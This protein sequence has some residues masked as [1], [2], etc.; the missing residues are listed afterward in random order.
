MIKPSCNV[1]GSSVDEFLPFGISAAF[2]FDD[3]LSRDVPA[4]ISK[5]KAHKNGCVS[6]TGV[7]DGQHDL[8]R[9]FAAAQDK[10]EVRLRCR[11]LHQ[12]EGYEPCGAWSHEVLEPISGVLLHERAL[13]L[14][15]ARGV[16]PTNARGRRRT[17]QTD[18]AGLKRA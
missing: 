13:V 17:R 18:G 8:A 14:I 11:G 5:R 15:V 1:G 7:T 3:Q 16:F 9:F 2:E 10:R 12:A 4:A 6:L